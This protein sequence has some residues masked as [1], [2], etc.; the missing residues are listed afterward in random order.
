MTNIAII[1]GGPAGFMAAITAAENNSH[2]KTESLNIN[3]LEKNIPLKTI[4]YTGNGRCNLT[5]ATYDN[6]ELTSNYPRGDKFLYSA[7]SRFGVKETMAW[8]N[9][10]GLELYTQKD[11]RVFPKSDDAHDVRNL[12][13]NTAQKLGINIKSHIKITKIE[14]AKDKFYVYTGNLPLEYDKIIMATGGNYRRLPDSGYNFA[15]KL[16][17]KI[18]Q[19]KPALTAFQTEETWFSVLAGVS[20]EKSEMKAFFQEKQAAKAEGDFIFTHK[21]ISGPLVFKISSY[22]AFLNYNKYSPLILKINFVP[23]KTPDE[24]NKELLKEFEENSKKSIENILK[25]YAPKSVIL[26]LLKTKLINPEKKACQIT[27]EE[28]KTIVKML[29]ETKLSVKSFEP[30][31]EIVTAGGIELNEVN[32]KTMESKIIKNLYFCGEILNI[33]GFTGGFNLQACWSTGYI[34][35]SE[36]GK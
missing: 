36:A 14:P 6:K 32:S 20:I 26:A 5:N 12:L 24:L 35:G 18:T 3:I 15:E 9:S 11:N 2:N 19:L 17:H 23:D 28:R 13:I 10:H 31:G 34:A 7:F 33:D 25:I 22:C 21:G 8:F 4:L 1:G 27:K 16:G 30:D 29:T